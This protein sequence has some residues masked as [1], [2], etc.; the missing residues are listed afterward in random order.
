MSI[1]RVF[2][3]ISTIDEIRTKFSYY[4]SA[5]NSKRNFAP[6]TEL[7]LICLAKVILASQLTC[8]VRKSSRLDVRSMF[9]LSRF[10]ASA[11]WQVEQDAT[12]TRI[13]STAQ[14]PLKEHW[15]GQLGS[16]AGRQWCFC[17]DLLGGLRRKQESLLSRLWSQHRTKSPEKKFP[18]YLLYGPEMA[19]WLNDELPSEHRQL[20]YT[21]NKPWN[22]E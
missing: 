18:F 8:E 11:R 2:A 10:S 17:L 1:L 6:L 16:T 13:G 12:T 21:R 14:T 19:S 22:W 15:G 7:S 9:C 4:I 20:T 3:K 5:L